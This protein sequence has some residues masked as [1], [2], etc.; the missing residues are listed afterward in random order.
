[1]TRR[2]AFLAI[3]A[4]AASCGGGDDSHEEAPPEAPQFAGLDSARLVPGETDV[5]ELT[6]TRATDAQTPPERLRYQLAVYV[7]R[8]DLPTYYD[9]SDRV[10]GTFRWA[11][12]TPANVHWFSVTVFDEQD[13][14]AGG[15]VIL[16]VVS[17]SQPPRIDSIDPERLEAGQLVTILGAYLLDEP[18]L[19]DAVTVGGQAIALDQLRWSSAKIQFY[20]P[21]NLTGESR[22]A[23]TTPFGRAEAA[24]PLLIDPPGPVG[25]D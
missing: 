25:H 15:D 5:V 8:D 3:A 23:V 1:M 18:V 12:L 22:I 10:D 24:D 4:L 16:P 14:Q 2:L 21:R 20:V 13:H 11:N 6:W 9:V 19:P 7:N 17:P